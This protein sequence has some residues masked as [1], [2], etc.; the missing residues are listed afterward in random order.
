MLMKDYKPSEKTHIINLKILGQIESG[1]KLN[2]RE[3]YFTLDTSI[4]SQGLRRLYRGDNRKAT[5]EKISDLVQNIGELI[6][7]RVN[8]QDA[9]EFKAYI[10]PIIE[11]AIKGLNSLIDTYVEDK[12]FVS[13]MEVEVTE[14]KEHLV[15]VTNSQM[16]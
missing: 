5:Y 9:E 14:L 16:I 4:W 11:Q 7:E 1:I 10:S 15:K 2:T 8:G 3:K 12:T 6:E 13:Q